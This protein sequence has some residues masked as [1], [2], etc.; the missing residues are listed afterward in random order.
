L[1]Q[2]VIYGGAGGRC[3]GLAFGSL[4]PSPPPH[5]RR[6]GGRVV[7]PGGVVPGG[8]FSVRFP[9][10]RS[11]LPPGRACFP[12]PRPVSRCAGCVC[13]RP[14]GPRRACARACALRGCGR[15]CCAGRA[16][17]A[18]GALCRAVLSFVRLVVSCCSFV[19]CCCLVRC[20]SHVTFW[21]V[22]RSTCVAALRA[23]RISLCQPYMPSG[24]SCMSWAF[25]HSGRSAS[26]RAST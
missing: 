16:T 26:E 10:R 15:W 22:R 20:S 18:G 12:C 21:C 7:R 19:L 11:P 8:R 24:R 6:S 13:L 9:A 14:F 1:R 17:R 25:A 5:P 23:F 4:S 3:V 2:R